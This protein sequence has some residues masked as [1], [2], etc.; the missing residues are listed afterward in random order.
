MENFDLRFLNSP[1]SYT[2]LQ[3]ETLDFDVRKAFLLWTWDI[4]CAHVPECVVM[5]V[6][7][8]QYNIP[9]HRHLKNK[10]MGQCMSVSWFFGTSFDISSVTVHTFWPIQSSFSITTQ[11]GIVGNKGLEDDIARDVLCST[12]MPFWL[13]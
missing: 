11:I 2:Y 12:L 3:I 9:T 13:S 7:L 4:S 10:K 5:Q 1:L 6:C 8:S